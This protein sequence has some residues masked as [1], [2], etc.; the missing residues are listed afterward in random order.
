LCKQSAFCRGCLQIK[1]RADDGK[2]NIQ[3]MGRVDHLDEQLR[4]YKAGF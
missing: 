3:F 2:L 4:P 1:K